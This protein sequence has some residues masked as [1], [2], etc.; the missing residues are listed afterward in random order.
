MLSSPLAVRAVAVP[1]LLLLLILAMALSLLV[2][3]KPLPASVIFDALSGTCQSA[4]CTIVLDARLPR[5]LA[6]LLA[7]AALGLAGALMQTLTRNPLADPGIL[8]VNAGASFAIVLGAALFGLSSPTEQLVMAFCGALAASLLVAFTGSQ[9]GGQLSP[10]RLTLAGVALGAV[11]E[12]LSSGIALLNPDVWDQLRFWQAGS[13]DIRTLQ[14][15]HIVTIPVLIAA[16]VALFLSRA[17]NSLSLGSDTA[18]ALGSRV[19]RTQLIGLLTITVLCGSATAVVGPIAFIGLMMP[20]MARWLVGAD[21]RW[22]LPVTLLATPVLL[23]FADIIGRVLVPGELR[24]SVVSAFIG[25]PVLIFLV[26][27]KRG[28]EL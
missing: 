16:I 2:G 18:T 27:R 15:L 5:T 1:F 17:L 14:T 10:V 11:L 28:G 3:A 26:R 20:H 7:G 22:S 23:L 21:H 9:G 8:G 6:G 12:G 24:V 19:A 4:D 13:L 25:A